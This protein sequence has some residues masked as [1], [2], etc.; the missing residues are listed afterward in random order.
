MK[1]DGEQIWRGIGVSIGI[2]IGPAYVI[3]QTGMLVPEYAVPAGQVEKELKRFQAA[4]VKTQRQLSQL[5]QKA[6]R[7]ISGALSVDWLFFS[8]PLAKF[9]FRRSKSALDWVT[10]TYMELSCWMVESAAG[11][12][13]VTSAPSVTC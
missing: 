10:S 5:K 4:L 12:P 7:H 1:N 6:P 11:W 8:R 13:A 3:D 9:C 2:A